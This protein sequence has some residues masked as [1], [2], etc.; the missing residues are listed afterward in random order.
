MAIKEHSK[1]VV[2]VLVGVPILVT[3]AILLMSPAQVQPK[4]ACF[5]VPRFGLTPCAVEGTWPVSLRNQ[6]TS[7]CF[8]GESSQPWESTSYAKKAPN[9]P[10]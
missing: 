3:W 2:P 9:D 7:L 4:A 1:V 5:V 8:N 6:E 10:N